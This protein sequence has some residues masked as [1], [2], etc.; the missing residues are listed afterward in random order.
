MLY[1]ARIATFARKWG[2]GRARLEWLSIAV[3]AKARGAARSCSHSCSVRL[4][5]RNFEAAWLLRQIIPLTVSWERTRCEPLMPIVISLC[6]ESEPEMLY[7]NH[8]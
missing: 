2:S 1:D 5:I 7:V 3:R 8:V 4:E 6:P